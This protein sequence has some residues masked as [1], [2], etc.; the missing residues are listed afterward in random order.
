MVTKAKLWKDFEPEM[1][2]YLSSKFNRDTVFL[3]VGANVGYYTLMAAPLVREVIAFEP[4]PMFR[5]QLEHEIAKMG[6]TN[7]TIYPIGL[8]SKDADGIMDPRRHKSIIHLDY[9]DRP[10]GYRVSMVTLDSLSLTPT[11]MKI[12]VEGAEMD[13]LL[14][15]RETL[16]AHRPILAIEVHHRRIE[17]YFGHRAAQVS[18]F[19][20][21]IGYTVSS[22]KPDGGHICAEFNEYPGQNAPKESQ[23]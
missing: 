10:G 1:G 17:K 20:Q 5:H 11:L 8:F 14:G 13:V 7:I 19:L 3:D 21:D 16:L 2:A 18:K 9:L 22:L 6:Y 23:D 4:Q 12:D 15:G